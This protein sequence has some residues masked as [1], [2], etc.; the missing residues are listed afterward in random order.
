MDIFV[1]GGTGVL[2]RPVITL[3][4]AAG[5]RVRG[6]AHSERAATEL[7]GLGAEP[8]EGDLF[9]PI[10]LRQAVA[11]ADAVLHLATRIPAATAMRSRGAWHENDRIRREGTRNLVDAALAAGTSTFVYPSVA[12]VYP[13]SG[14]TWIDAATTPPQPSTDVLPST[15]DAEAEVARFSAGG[16]RGVVLRM[17]RFY[18]ADRF[19]GVDRFSRDILRAARRGVGMVLGDG[20]VYQSAIWIDDAAT[21][22]VAALDT[23]V[24]PGIYDVVDDEPLRQRELLAVLAHAV[25]RRRVRRIPTAVARTVSGVLADYIMRSQRVSNRRFRE[26]SGWTPSVPSAR[27][28]WRRLAAESGDRPLSEGRGT[29][30]ATRG[31]KVWLAALVAAALPV[32]SWQLFAPRSFYEDF[33]GFGRVWVSADGP[34]NEHLMRDVGAGTLALGAVALVAL[35]WTTPATLRAAAAGALV[36]SV[37]HF[38]YHAVHLDRLPSTTDQV[39]QTI[40]LGFAPVAAVAL[41]WMAARLGAPRAGPRTEQEYAYGGSRVTGHGS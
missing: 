1:T 7:R 28:G 25:G 27:D 6:L 2:G 39:A 20:D 11:G 36:S 9:D 34:F 12:F 4:V 33:P 5:H 38:I 19:H 16:G 41:F 40:T 8:V 26:A 23:R 14:D 32:G 31:A 22:V 10:S 21:A 13:D 24:Q 17:G 30:P 37:P 3:L 15:I 29:A 35:L 18:G